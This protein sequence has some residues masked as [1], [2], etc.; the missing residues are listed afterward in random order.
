M[1]RSHLWLLANNAALA[2]AAGRS[3]FGRA[4]LLSSAAQTLGMGGGTKR[5][6]SAAR[7][8][9]VGGPEDGAGVN[10]DVTRHNFKQV[11]GAA[12]GG[13]CHLAAPLLATPLPAAPPT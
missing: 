13:P 12:G 1:R 4:P 10:V 11:R 5:G 8:A 9:A 6:A 3:L 2:A 7:S